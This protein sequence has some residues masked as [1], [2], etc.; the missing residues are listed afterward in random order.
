M[1]DKCDLE[2]DLLLEE[3]KS[4]R[5]EQMNKMDKQYMITGLGI[6]GIAALLT[7]AFEKEIYPLFLILPLVILAVMTLYEAESYAIIRAGE[8]IK[9]FEENFITENKNLGWERWLK[10]KNKGTIYDLI[11]HSSRSILFFLYIGCILGIYAFPD[12]GGEF[13]FLSEIE[14]RYLLF[15][16]YALIGVVFISVCTIRQCKKRSS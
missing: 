8:Y 6:G 12:D 13:G 16:I 2:R 5:Q 10:E 9:A 15:A 7:A 1:S 14:F 4:L 3:Y 11:D